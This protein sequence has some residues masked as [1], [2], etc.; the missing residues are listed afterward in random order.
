MPVSLPTSNALPPGNIS[1]GR[2]KESDVRAHSS[3]SRRDKLI[4]AAKQRLRATR[5]IVTSTAR[6]VFLKAASG[7]RIGNP[8]T[9]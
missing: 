4:V 8:Q 6:S 2:V 1:R 7:D 3:T 9:I 5:I